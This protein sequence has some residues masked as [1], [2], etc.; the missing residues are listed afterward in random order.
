MT[1][2]QRLFGRG[3]VDREID[4]ELRDHVERQIAD[5][6]ASGPDRGGSPTARAGRLWRRRAGRRVVPRR[7][8][9]PRRRRALAGRALRPPGAAQEPGVCGRRRPVAGAWHRRHHGDLLARRCGPAQDAA[10][11]R[12]RGAR[13]AL[14]A[15]RR[16]RR[17]LVH[18][19]TSSGALAR[20]MRLP[21]CARS[22]RGPASGST[23]AAGA[24]LAMGQL[25]SGNCFEVLGLSPVLGRLLQAADDRGPGGP[26][27]AV[28]SYDFWQRHF[29]GDVGIVG[30]SFD[31]MGQP[32]TVVGVTPREFF[33]LE[34]GRAIDITVPLSVQPLLLPGHAA[35]DVCRRALASPHRS[36]GA[37]T[38]R[39]SSSA[40][41]W[42]ARWSLLE[43]VR[44]R[45]ADQRPTLAVLS[46]AQ[47]LNDLRRAYSLPLRL[48]L[49]AVTRAAAGRVREPGGP[50][51][52]ARQGA[53]TRD[54]PSPLPRR[55]PLPHR[56]PDAHR[57]RAHLAVRQPR[58]SGAGVLGSCG[59]AGFVVARHEADRARRAR[60]RAAARLHDGR[61][62]RDDAAVRAVAGPAR[63]RRRSSSAPAHDHA[64]EVD[65]PPD[66]RADCGADGAGGRA[67]CRRRRCSSEASRRCTPWTLASGK[68]RVLL[69]SIR[70]A[71]GGA[72]E[73]EA[74]RIYRELYTRLYEPCWRP[75]GD[76][77]ARH[78]A[79]RPIDDRGNRR[80]RMAV[81]RS[82]A[83]S[84]RTS[85]SSVRDSWRRWACRL[86][87]DAISARPTTSVR[88]RR[89]SSARRSPGGCSGPTAPSAAS[90]RGTAGVSRSSASPPTCAT[91]ACGTEPGDTVYFTYFNMP[92]FA[93]GADL[94]GED[95]WQSAG[96]RRRRSTAGARGLSAVAHLQRCRA[97]T[98]GTTAASPP[99]GCWRR[100]PDSSASLALL[101]V[102][103]GVYG[104]LAYAAARRTREMGVRLALGAERTDIVRLLLSGRARR[105]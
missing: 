37:G 62:G 61:D 1:L 41:R 91:R 87:V 26:L 101:L 34:P 46:G 9:W 105:R 82:L 51:A 102:S 69:A 100:S 5:Y 60:R 103:V 57:G 88:R 44:T 66:R 56:P 40:P 13:A 59:G 72:D 17:L 23:T 24:E 21:G 19:R 78:A 67:G 63:E 27:V 95:R 55:K 84:R 10:G 18:H 58:R 76:A 22:G 35:A 97:S 25:V 50:V 20:T 4:A 36:A 29:S 68:M 45:P 90:S 12:S 79:W 32:F 92:E 2:W 39:E 30:R 86:S 48:L 104:T 80:G 14:S 42:A 11:S 8:A 71:V 15:R 81:G 74:R 94:R 85:T 28:I 64:V 98:R 53:P 6:R 38:D 70:P 77:D 49:A 43:T 93:R 33:G 54:R 31:L 7:V 75:R 89:R 47:G 99:N 96:A 3:R 52:R 73:V 83:S 16:S 65:W